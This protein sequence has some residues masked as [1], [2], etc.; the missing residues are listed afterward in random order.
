MTGYFITNSGKIEF[1]FGKTHFLHNK[2]VMT[3]FVQQTLQQI[4]VIIDLFN[5]ATEPNI[6]N[7]RE[8]FVYTL[9]RDEYIHIW[10]E[11]SLHYVEENKADY[12][13]SAEFDWMNGTKEWT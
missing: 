10:N 6:F 11:K 7:N 2:S 5:E 12:K 1:Y 8:Y 13:I 9:T 3:D 4:H